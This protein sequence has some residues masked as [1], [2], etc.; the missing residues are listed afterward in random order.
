METLVYFVPVIDISWERFGP[1]NPRK[2]YSHS[3]PDMAECA[4]QCSRVLDLVSEL[5]DGQ[6]G[7]AV[8][9]G[10]YCRDGFH[11]PEFMRIWKTCETRG[12]EI[13]LHTHEEIAS[14]GTHN[15]D[16]DH[17]IRVINS[18]CE[19][20]KRANI[21]PVGYR[22][23]LYGYAPFLTSFLEKLGILMDFSAAPGVERPDRAAYWKSSPFSAWYLDRKTLYPGGTEPGG[24]LEIPLGANG[25][26]SDNSD[27]MYIDYDLAS[28]ESVIKL[29]DLVIQRA[30]T[31]NCVQ[32]IHTLFHSFS[33]DVPVCVERYK[34]FTEYALTHGGE[35][36]TPSRIKSLYDR[37]GIHRR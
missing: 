7:V 2:K 8:H 21:S 27:L 17:M 25:Q 1:L 33:V 4:G 6:C 24:V 35:A 36:A 28:Q 22:G 5:Y 16:E 19:T 37:Q 31:E 15:S 32:Y 11:S 34:R 9:T 3:P 12:G 13:L 26:G 30:R 10:T 14:V 23:G 29:W 18:Q 20:L